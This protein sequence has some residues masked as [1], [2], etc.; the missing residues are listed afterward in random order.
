[1]DDKVTS[2]AMPGGAWESIKK[3]IRAYNAARDEEAPTVESIASLAGVHRP[4]ISKN[5]NFLRSVGILQKD[6]NKLTPLGQQFAT[7]LALNNEPLITDTLRQII[8]D[9]PVLLRLV[10]VLRARGEVKLDV[11]K[12]QVIVQAGLTESSPNIAYVRAL[13]D[14]FIDAEIMTLD[15]DTLFL[16]ESGGPSPS[17]SPSAPVSIPS[18]PSPSASPSPSPSAEDYSDGDRVPIALGPNRRV[19]IELPADWNSKKDLGKL[20]KLLQ[21]SL[22]DDVEGAKTEPASE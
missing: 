16:A 10:N 19:Y 20:L 4:V 11:F 5:N 21:L 7:G 8:L 22:G 3:I 2:F 15:G 9:T 17:F 14:M 13:L 6:K 18:S 12:A 1:M